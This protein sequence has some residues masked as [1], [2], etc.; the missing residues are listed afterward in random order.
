M[1]EFL[2]GQRWINTAQLQMGLGT[3]V[4]ADFRTVTIEF[5]ST[6][7]T[8]V[9]A[10]ESVPLTRV[11]FAPGDATAEDRDAVVARLRQ[12]NMLASGS[13]RIRTEPLAGV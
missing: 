7:E 9:Y 12:L 13:T 11:R 1:T 10:R 3:V 2:P 4:T 8:F 5:P 6:G